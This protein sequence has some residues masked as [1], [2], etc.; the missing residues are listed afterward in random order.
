MRQWPEYACCARSVCQIRAASMIALNIPKSSRRIRISQELASV[1]FCSCFLSPLPDTGLTPIR[2]P[3]QI[4]SLPALRFLLSLYILYA[5]INHTRIHLAA[6]LA[7]MIPA[8][9]QTSKR[10]AWTLASYRSSENGNT[11]VLLLLTALLALNLACTLQ[12]QR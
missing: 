11:D 9:G 10:T 5:H 4:Q 7:T 6:R 12:S 3:L 1:P 2:S 8:S